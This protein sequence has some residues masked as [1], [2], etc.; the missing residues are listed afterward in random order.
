MTVSKAQ[1]EDFASRCRETLERHPDYK[2]VELEDFSVSDDSPMIEISCESRRFGDEL[3]TFRFERGTKATWNTN[4]I[5]LTV[6]DR[7]CEV[8]CR[9]NSTIPFDEKTAKFDLEVMSSLVG[10]DPDSLLQSIRI[11]VAALKAVNPPQ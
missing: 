11:I 3:V 4:G 7:D 9:V 6:S 8:R 10:G 1:I 2:D 5:D